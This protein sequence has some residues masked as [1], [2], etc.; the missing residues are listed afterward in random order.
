[1]IGKCI[2]TTVITAAMLCFSWLSPLQAEIKVSASLTQQQVNLNDSFELRV[3][4]SGSK[5][6]AAINPDAL[7]DFYVI[8]QGSSQSFHFVNNSF[9]STAV[10]IFTLKAKRKGKLIIPAFSIKLEGKTYKT[11]PLT[12]TVNEASAQ[13]SQKTA[14]AQFKEKVSAKRNAD[15]FI[16][17]YVDKE[18]AYIGEVIHYRLLLF[19]SVALLSDLSYELPDFGNVSSESLQRDTK[20][21]EKVINGRR[22]YVQEIDKH[23]LM[24]YEAG[25]LTISPA[26][27]R[28][29]L[30]VFYSSQ[31]LESNP[32]TVSVLPLP[33]ASKPAG[34]SGIV[35]D[36]QLTTLIDDT[37]AIQNKPISIRMKVS[38][39]GDLK[40]I[41]ALNFEPNDA[42][43]IYKSSVKDQIAYKDT[44]KGV[45]ELEYIVVPKEEGD[46]LLPQFSLSYFSPK[47][48]R[49]FTVSTPTKN[50]SVI[51]SALSSTVLNAN[52]ED[53]TLAEL[54]Q[55]L[56]YI[57]T[58]IFPSH[59][60]F[61]FYES[62][63]GL[64]VLF[65][66]CVYLLIY[67]LTILFDKG[68][69]SQLQQFVK[70]KP[71][72]VAMNEL[73]RVENMS[74]ISE[75]CNALQVLLYDYL[76]LVIQTPAKALTTDVLKQKLKGQ[77]VPE[78]SISDLIAVLNRCDFIGYAPSDSQ[79][80][81]LKDLIQKV[82]KIF[83]DLK[84]YTS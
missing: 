53:V 26:L 3:S 69:G 67:I 52:N 84:G 20:T 38:G 4:V 43:K 42:Y 18:K 79:E 74:V 45:R 23:A 60:G 66:L 1:M 14:A 62:L 22:Y 16:Q 32:L 39:F 49:Y 73:R 68:L 58:T 11:Q 24:A 41:N 12:I 51:S 27:V 70:K 75:Q 31:V 63:T 2:K 82:R 57:H 30:G 5:Q 25:E 78:Q 15:I 64:V 40:Q 71:Y 72:K 81:S 35:G 47:E 65:I 59:R 61:I 77:Q 7:T 10:T 9:S 83:E 34:F 13:A 36:Y 21:Y 55:D 28:V 29:Q 56:R 44:I 33:E 76:S 80:K 19:R 37:A 50:V 17:A 6:K 8:G 54:A 48:K 46:M